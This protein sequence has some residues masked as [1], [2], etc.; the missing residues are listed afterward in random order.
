MK[1]NRQDRGFNV[2]RT[3]DNR[4]KAIMKKNRKFS[5]LLF[6]SFF[7]LSM[8]GTVTAVMPPAPPEW[9]QRIDMP[10]PDNLKSGPMPDF[11]H[12][13]KDLAEA[14]RKRPT[15][16][17][18]ILVILVEFAD[19][20]ADQ[21][22]HPPQ[23]YDDMMFS[24]GVIPTG[25]LVEYYQEISYGAFTP[26]GT[27]T[28]WITAPHDYLYY[29]DGSYG[30]GSHPNNSQ[31]LLEDCVNYLDPGIDFSQF[32]NNGDGY[33]EGIFLV[34]SGP[35][36]EET[37][38]PDDI[39]SH[40]W[41]YGVETDDGVSTG[42]YSVEPESH[43]DGSM[44]AIGVFCHEYGHVLGMPDLYDT[45]GS[46]E[47][48]GVYC[49]MAGGSWGALPG[50]PERPTHMSAEMKRRLG[51]L[52]PTLITGSLT[53]LE[54]P[55]VATNPVCYRIDHPYNPDE[56]FLFENRARVGFDSLFRGDGGLAI[57]HVDHD[58]W[59][60]DESHRYVS[61]MQADGNGDLE[62]DYGT[63]NRHPRT[64]R[65]DA[66]DLY[67]GASGN[68]HFTFASH[69]Y[70]Y[71][72]DLTTAFATVHN[73]SL[74]DDTV[75]A[76]IMAVPDIPVY[77]VSGVTVDDDV[78]RYASNMNDEADSGEVVDLIIGLSCEGEGASSLTGTLRTDDTRVA[79]IDSV[80]AFAP[81]AHNDETSN[82]LSRFRIEVLSASTDSVVCLGLHLDADG[83]I[84]DVECVM[85]IN[86]QKILVVLDNNYS[87]WSDNL[88]EAMTRT[89][90]SFDT[91]WNSIAAG[92]NRV[93]YDDLIGYHAVL[94]TTASYFG[95]RTSSPDYNYCLS[96]DEISVLQEY[97]D[98]NGRLGLFSQDYLYDRGLDAFA[99][100]Y[101]HVGSFADDQGSAGYMTGVQGPF[102]TGQDYIFKEWSFYDY[103]DHITPASGAYPLV[104]DD[105]LMGVTMIGY[106]LTPQVGGFAT[107]FAAFGP[108]RLD[109]SSLVR[110]LT[111]W[112]DWVMQNTNIDVPLPL[113]PIDDSLSTAPVFQWTASEGAAS[114]NIQ[115]ATDFEFTNIIRETSVAFNSTSF[116]EPFENG[117]YFWRV[118]A[119][120][121]SKATT[122]YSPRAEFTFYVPYV[123][124]DANGDSDANIGDAVYII[125][126]VFKSGPA[127]TPL[128]TGDA[129]GD[130]DV[131]VGDAVY[132]INYV[133]NNGPE[134]VEPCC[135]K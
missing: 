30:T 59:Q 74:A 104:E 43:Y 82:N 80:A 62:R 133:F 107:S 85:N 129:N 109:D 2:K 87:H 52:T 96:D 32:D 18:N 50:N 114:Y 31:G 67:P 15:N 28:V 33:A 93:D 66:G 119:T 48:I 26:A 103:T 92:P 44:I 132:L 70:S 126:F 42:R 41:Y 91:L 79:L 101:L 13:R 134:P 117:T 10:I 19:Q 65:G 63:G 118:N 94:W 128:C 23:A 111:A 22:N 20:P 131:N 83:D 72:Y 89:G 88:L 35:G 24:T 99:S 60:S 97:L 34:H 51:W 49:L 100:N 81:V 95:R 78:V 68:D 53:G 5:A 40:A 127:P 86:R 12:I 130:G 55:P 16:T 77:H 11:S 47:G 108:E 56:Y 73:I 54:I 135:N 21:F 58:G 37:G 7:L 71:D 121:E 75:T 17:D 112:C 115:V 4:N 120:P 1:L 64:N 76:D 102:A 25:S 6:L 69:P 106:P 123:C 57:W 39:W 110:L 27:V 36:A 61:L 98:N 46:S 113:S 90:Y 8:S 3:F 105:S 84:F 124:G 38:D 45:D 125:N 9:Y 116:T 122:A 14:A 29:S